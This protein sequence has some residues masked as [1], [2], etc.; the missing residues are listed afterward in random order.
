MKKKCVILVAEALTHFWLCQPACQYHSMWTHIDICWAAKRIDLEILWLLTPSQINVWKQLVLN[1]VNFN[2]LNEV[3]LHQKY[4]PENVWA[5]I[6]FIQ[7][8]KIIKLQLNNDRNSS[9]KL[10]LVFAIKIQLFL[11]ERCLIKVLMEMNF[12]LQ[13]PYIFIYNLPSSF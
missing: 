1:S 8:K 5:K 2:W 3:Y 13:S 9:W 6:Q 12:I 11:F 7:T 4:L 10:S